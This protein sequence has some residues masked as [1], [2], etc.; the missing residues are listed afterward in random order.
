[1]EEVNRS[2]KVSLDKSEA[3]GTID[4]SL[5]SDDLITSPDII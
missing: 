4:K 2:D 1:M 5:A 3:I